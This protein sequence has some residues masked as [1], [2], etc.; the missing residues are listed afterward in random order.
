M[1]VI[2]SASGMTRPP[3]CELGSTTISNATSLVAPE[4]NPFPK[5]DRPA[6][7]GSGFLIHHGRNRDRE[8]PTVASVPALNDWWE[9]GF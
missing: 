2:F 6:W 7:V 3:A 4:S 9:F 8:F 5:I 1:P